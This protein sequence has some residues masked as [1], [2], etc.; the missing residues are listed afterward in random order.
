MKSF[1]VLL[2]MVSIF[3]KVLVTTTVMTTT[4]MIM[5]MMMV[6]TKPRRRRKLS[7]LCGRQMDEAGQM[8]SF[9]GAEIFLLLETALQLV[10][11]SCCH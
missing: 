1:Y 5:T 2:I 9:R 10:H 6:L 3:L 8:F 7:D 4:M 11:L